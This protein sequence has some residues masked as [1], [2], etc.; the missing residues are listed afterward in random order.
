MSDIKEFCPVSLDAAADIIC[1][2][3][4][5]LI[6]FHVHPDGDSVGS[7]FALRAFVESIGGKAWCVCADQLPD[8]LLF[9]AE[10]AQESVLV[11]D[12]LIKYR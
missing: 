4:N 1:N 9:A 7:A 2:N 11:E 5:I 6:L 12:T 3:K 8:R 10:G